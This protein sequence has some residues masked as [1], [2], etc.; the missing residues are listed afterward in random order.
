MLLAVY[1]YLQASMAAVRL[2]LD[3]SKDMDFSSPRDTINAISQ[4]LRTLYKPYAGAQFRLAF[5]RDGAEQFL[6]A[7]VLFRGQHVASRTQETYRQGDKRFVFVEYWCREQWEAVT[8][9]SKLLS[10]QAEIEGHLIK[11][12]F[13]RSEFSQRTYPSGRNWWTGYELRSRRD[14]DENWRELYVPQGDLV[15]RG[16]SPYKGPDHAINDW[17]FNQDTWNLLGADLPTKDTIVTVFPDSRAR[18]LSADWQPELKK[19]YLEIELISAA[20]SN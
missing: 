8:L 14:R 7:A 11:A 12:T 10:G 2:V 15:R 9:L 20:R 19:L 18:I 16:A 4:H 3:K 5:L 17:I 6:T 13:S 1:S